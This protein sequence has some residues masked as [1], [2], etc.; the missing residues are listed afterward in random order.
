LFEAVQ[1]AFGQ[2]LAD[3]EREE[4]GLEAGVI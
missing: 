4:A 2:A 3:E 1:A